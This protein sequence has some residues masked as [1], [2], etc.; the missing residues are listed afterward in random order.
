MNAPDRARFR[1]VQTEPVPLKGFKRSRVMTL[2]EKQPVFVVVA[3]PCGVTGDLV[4]ISNVG[5]QERVVVVDADRYRD[6]S[7]LC[8]ADARLIRPG[9][10]RHW[11]ILNEQGAATSCH[12]PYQCLSGLERR[13]CRRGRSICRLHRLAVRARFGTNEKHGSNGDDHDQHEQVQNDNDLGSTREPP[14]KSR[15][16]VPLIVHGPCLPQ[17]ELHRAG[18]HEEPK[19]C[20]PP[21]HS[22]AP[23]L[24]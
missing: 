7:Q 13:D 19:L 2:Q 1:S 16:R 18:R 10:G 24:T 23:P 8:E 22:T 11:K 5:S 14:P 15:R 17:D 3:G 20:L 12:N 21:R 6:A 4:R 9:Q